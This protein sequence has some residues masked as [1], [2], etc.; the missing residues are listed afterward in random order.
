MPPHVKG[1]TWG[2][3]LPF[4]LSETK[5]RIDGSKEFSLMDVGFGYVR[6]MFCPSSETRVVLTWEFVLMNVGFRNV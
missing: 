5:R 3:P 1:G 2:R 4:K 6:T